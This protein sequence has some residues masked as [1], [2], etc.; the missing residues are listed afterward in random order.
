M[1][2]RAI[3]GA[4]SVP[5]NAAEAIIAATRDMLQAALVAN[6]IGPEDVV[7]IVFA[8]TTDLDAAFPAR[9]AREG[10]GLVDVPLLDV[11]SPAVPG[12]VQR[13]VRMLLTC[14]TDL[15]RHAIHHVYLGDAQRLR[16]DLVRPAW[17]Q[18]GLPDAIVRGP[19]TSHGAAPPHQREVE[20]R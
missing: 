2:V 11:V 15:P 18:R 5:A 19:C 4:T 20:E 7:S 1:A 3:R 13:V 10:L 12:A 14:E 17:D 6:G 16:P 8:V 9:A